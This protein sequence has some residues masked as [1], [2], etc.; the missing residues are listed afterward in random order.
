MTS[1]RPSFRL[2]ARGHDDILLLIPGWATDSRI[3]LTLDLPYNY[4]MAEGLSPFEFGKNLW[5][6]LEKTGHGRIS[7][8]GWSMGSFLA[9]ELIAE[10]PDRFKEAV[11]ISARK[12]YEARSIEE[13][14]LYLKKN[15]KGYLYK[16]YRAF[17][18]EDD[19]D[20]SSW[21]EK[22]LLK[23]Y[24]AEMDSGL[25]AEGLDYLLKA[26]L[27]CG[28]LI[29]CD[30]KFVHGTQDKIA[31]FCEARSVSAGLPRAGFIPVE[32]AGHAPF[33]RPDFSKILYGP[34][35]G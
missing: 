15:K 5:S 24:L 2:V 29:D 31:P 14:K 21:F 23:K 13:I 28:K 34:N 10:H 32:G 7:V 8:L 4:L 16:F 20:I 3:F 25:L 1:R 6:A 12:R 33:L 19:R 26:E 30:V 9:S 18:S 35:D 27:D 22:N 11:L 17:F